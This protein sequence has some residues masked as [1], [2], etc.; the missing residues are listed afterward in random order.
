MDISKKQFKIVFTNDCI[1]EMDEIYAYISKKLSMPNSSKT[2]MKKV[3]NAINNLKV[4]PNKYM[5]IKKDNALKLEYRRIVINNFV[6]LYTISEE[7]ETIYIVHMYYG[8]I[9]Y[10]NKI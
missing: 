1:I 8:G 3:E 4:M 7:N 10:L 5:I 9:D 6:I 2:L